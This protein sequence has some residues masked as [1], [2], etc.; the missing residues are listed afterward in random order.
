MVVDGKLFVCA[1]WQGHGTLFGVV[2]Q[3]GKWHGVA[4]PWSVTVRKIISALCYAFGSGVLERIVKEDFKLQHDY[5]ITGNVT[6]TETI[7]RS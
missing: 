7:R 6:V 5:N 1:A 2:G 4:M 3:S